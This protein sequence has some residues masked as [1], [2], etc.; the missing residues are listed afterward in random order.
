MPTGFESVTAA[1]AAVDEATTALGL[2]V[3]DLIDQINKTATEGLNG[4]QTEGVLAHLASWKATLDAMGSNPTNPLPT[5][6]P[7]PGALP[8]PFRN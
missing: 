4:P 8:G 1:I 3:Q 5:P 6:P 2:R 7:V